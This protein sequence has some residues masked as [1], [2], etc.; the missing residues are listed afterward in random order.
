MITTLQNFIND[1]DLKGTRRNKYN[2]SR[3]QNDEKIFKIPHQC[4]KNC[5]NVLI[6]VSVFSNINKTNPC[7]RTRENVKL[8]QPLLKII[9]ISKTDFGQG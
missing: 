1:Q 5:D 4:Y 8:L 7:L 3:W 2:L 6:Q 9:S